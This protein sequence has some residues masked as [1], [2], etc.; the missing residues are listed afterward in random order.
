M[1]DGPAPSRRRAYARGL[2]AETWAAW[3]LRAK[4][5]RV[6]DRRFKAA[7]GEVDLIAARGRLLVFAE[8]KA[9]ASFEAALDAVGTA[10]ARRIAAA[11]E[12]WVARHPALAD[13]DQRF[14]VILMVPWRLPRHLPDAFRPD[15]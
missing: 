11:A 9:R 3:L 6:L 1:T 2:A 12:V 8:V 10:S 7:H 13:H 4:G 14:D 15:R 5:F